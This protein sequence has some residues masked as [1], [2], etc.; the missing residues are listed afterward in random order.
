MTIKPLLLALVPCATLG[1]ATLCTST[2]VQSQPDASSP[3]IRVLKAGSE[4]PAPAEGV[5]AVP[6]WTAVQLPPPFEAWVRNRDLT[7][8]LNVAPGT[9]L[10]ISPKDGAGVLTVFAQGDKADIIGLKGSWTQVRVDKALV[11]YIHATLP[12]ASAAPVAPVQGAAPAPPDAFTHTTTT[13]QAPVPQWEDTAGL[14]RLFDGTLTSTH[15]LL[16]PKQ[17][18]DWEIDDQDGHRIAFVDL[19]KILLT[20]QIENYAG[21]GVVVLGSLSPLPGSLE[22]VIH[23]EGLR[24]K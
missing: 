9:S 7:K 19:S 24:L 2:A 8:E 1:A 10:L 12:P 16:S 6:G 18:F 13:A 23:A 17:P 14:S 4:Q 22:L 11:G 20:D 3:V 15:R 5:P 21:H